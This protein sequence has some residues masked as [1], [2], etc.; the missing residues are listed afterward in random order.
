M[1]SLF[2]VSVF[3]NQAS[4]FDFYLWHVYF[5]QIPLEDIFKEYRSILHWI[6]ASGPVCF[7]GLP[8][9][10]AEQPGNVIL[11]FVPQALDIC[12]SYGT[13]NMLIVA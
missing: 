11:D 4:S 6:Q 1:L 8:T 2:A 9:P 12:Y 10:D 3:K 5:R 13:F 7:L